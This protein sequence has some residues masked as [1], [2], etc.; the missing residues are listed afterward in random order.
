M[1][2]LLF[3]E[4][5]YY[6]TAPTTKSG[7]FFVPKRIMNYFLEYWAMK[8]RILETT[9]FLSLGSLAAIYFNDV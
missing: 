7:W 6:T 4:I 2:P 1:V 5:V 8:F 3:L 9:R